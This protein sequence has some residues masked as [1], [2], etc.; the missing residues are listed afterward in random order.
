MEI[1]E[2][3]EK[4]GLNNIDELEHLFEISLIS[5]ETLLLRQ[6][7]RKIVSHLEKIVDLLSS[8]LHPDSSLIQI[9]DAHALDDRDRKAIMRIIKDFSLLLKDDVL[10][11]VESE[12]DAEKEFCAKA[13]DSYKASISKIKEIV[14]K[15]KSAYLSDDIIKDDVGYVG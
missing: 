14:V 15:I 5:D 7:R 8:Y 4:T 13:L 9:N 10:L 2:I 1:K 3:K 12:D 6:I 11:E